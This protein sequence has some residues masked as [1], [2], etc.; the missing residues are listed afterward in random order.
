MLSILVVE[1][2]AEDRARMATILRGGGYGEI[3]L[4]SSIAEALSALGIGSE[5][6]TGVAS[7]LGVELIILGSYSADECVDACRRIKDAFQYHDLPIMITAATA[8]AD[9]LP[10]A[11]AY[12]AIDYLRKPIHDLEFLARVRAALRLKYEIDRRKA[13]ER[14][15][16]E[17]ARQLADLNAALTRLSLVDSLTTVA[18]RRHFDRAMDK[19]WRRS[20]RGSREIS[21]IMI[22]IDYF[23]IYNDTY[24]HQAGDE[25][26]KIVACTIK[27]ALHRPGDIVARYGGEEFAIILPDTPATGAATVA[28]NLRLAVESAALPHIGS[29]LPSKRVTVSL[30]VACMI[31]TE[32]NSSKDL[33]N[34]ADQALYGAKAGGRNR[35]QIYAGDVPKKSKAS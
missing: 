23:K 10:V 24:G 1:T 35:V 8:S 30:G 26:L 15:L 16:L 4:S 18:N 32:A 3:Q 20:F 5:G 22:D 2:V 19:E 31:P 12:G 33:V 14:E 25:C 7:A 21:L 11:V 6:S 17:A 13:R 9:A 27:D 34:M 29:K 28:E